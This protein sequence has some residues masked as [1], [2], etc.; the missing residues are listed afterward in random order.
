MLAGEFAPVRPTR[1]KELC[2]AGYESVR[3]FLSSRCGDVRVARA[4]VDCLVLG[5]RVFVL[6]FSPFV[7]F[8]RKSL[9]ASA[10]G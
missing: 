9:E 2:A 8:V 1:R 4:R 7:R 6:I 3:R 5:V 10:T